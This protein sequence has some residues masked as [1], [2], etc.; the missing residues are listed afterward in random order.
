MSSAPERMDVDHPSSAKRIRHAISTGLSFIETSVRNLSGKKPDL[1]KALKMYSVGTDKLHAVLA[2]LD[3]TQSP[4]PSAE[5]LGY[6]G[7]REQTF[8]ADHPAVLEW[9]RYFEKLTADAEIFRDFEERNPTSSLKQATVVA[10][11][12]HRFSAFMPWFLCQAAAM[13]SSNE[14]R[15]Y[16]IQTA[17]EELGMRDVREI[18]PDMFW[19]AAE[20]AGVNVAEREQTLNAPAPTRVLLDLRAA[21]L[22]YKTDEE[23][24]GILLGLEIPAIENIETVFSSLAHNE[25]SR[26]RLYAHKFFRLH[27][28]IETEHVRLTVS[29]FLR[30]CTTEE[31]KDLFVRGFNDGLKF[32]RNFW[33]SA[34]DTI[35]SFSQAGAR[36]V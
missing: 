12:W 13:V 32:W 35:A 33:D 2:E 31:Q 19:S 14:K 20:L 16:V 22:S 30:F 29:N 11:L 34:S 7:I 3:Q 27:R 28:Q 21:L 5:A 26:S 9:T 8:T 17:F 25:I 6:N 36:N 4:S 24:L 10:A 23:V 15:H 1:P 18:H